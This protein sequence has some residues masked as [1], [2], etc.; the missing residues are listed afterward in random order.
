MDGKMV[1]VGLRQIY[2]LIEPIKGVPG[3]LPEMSARMLKYA[4]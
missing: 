4:E 2:L 1:H 3:D